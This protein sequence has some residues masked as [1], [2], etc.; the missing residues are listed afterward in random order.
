MYV[1]NCKEVNLGNDNFDKCFFSEKR[2]SSKNISSSSKSSILLHIF[3][4]DSQY[5]LASDASVLFKLKEN[6]A[7][8]SFYIFDYTFLLMLLSQPVIQKMFYIINLFF[9]TIQSLNHYRY[10]W[11]ILM[12]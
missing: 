6:I 10:V 1:R 5:Q 9:K 4:N 3:K 8:F 11:Y 2:V 12:Y 7:I